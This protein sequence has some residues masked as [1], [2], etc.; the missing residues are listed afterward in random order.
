MAASSLCSCIVARAQ[1]WPTTSANI[2]FWYL[3]HVIP[4][5]SP[6]SAHHFCSPLSAH[7][8]VKPLSA[9]HS[10]P[11][12]YALLGTP[13]LRPQLHSHLVVLRGPRCPPLGEGTLHVERQHD[14]TRSLVG[15]LLRPAMWY[16]QEGAPH[17]RLAVGAVLRRHEWACVQVLHG[18]VRIQ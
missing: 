18:V 12:A 6:L 1:L 10:A 16:G 17:A 9:H 8:L 13:V 5:C 3:S 4:H 2:P 14:A 7:P 15:V 11:Y